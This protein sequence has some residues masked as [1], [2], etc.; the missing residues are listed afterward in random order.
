MLPFLRSRHVQYLLRT[1]PNDVDSDGCDLKFDGVN[2]L[3]LV[4]F[5]NGHRGDAISPDLA[6]L[7]TTIQSLQIDRKPIDVP[8]IGPTLPVY[9]LTPKKQHE[10]DRM[11]AYIRDILAQ[12]NIPTES[13]RIVDVGAGQGYLTRSLAYHLRPAYILALDSNE[14]QSIAAQKWEQKILP[15]NH[16]P[17]SHKTVHITSTSLKEAIDEWIDATSAASVEPV[18]V[19]IVAL[20]ACGSLTPSILRA[21]ASQSS[22]SPWS[23]AGLVIVG[24]CYNLLHPSDLP[25]CD[26]PSLDLPPSAPALAA[27]IPMTW[28]DNLPSVSLAVK[29]VVWR[30]ILSREMARKG[31]SDS[32]PRLWREKSAR[33][34]AIAEPIDG[35]ESKKLI[36]I[37][38]SPAMRRLGKLRD[39]L[40]NDWPEFLRVAGERLGVDFSDASPPEPALENRLAVLHTL[41]CL[42]GPVVETFLIQDRIQFLEEGLRTHPIKWQVEA[43]NLFDQRTGSG[44]N[45]ALVVIP[46]IVSTTSQIPQPSLS[47]E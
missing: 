7:I 4:N 5:Y 9:G 42:L 30:A 20:H 40:Y 17:I 11:T 39:G 31:L 23:F 29:K 46:S 28:M 16:T 27:Q 43:V 14:A 6:N 15:P 47:I 36:G 13:L 19:L 41:R 26:I 21:F 18:P 2:W 1:H 10:V 35:D 45:V 32:V 22:A 44:R 8:P 3:H 12:N 34:N 24:C 25:L 38:T 33:E 37:G